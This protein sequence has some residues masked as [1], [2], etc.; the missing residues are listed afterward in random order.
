MA[1]PPEGGL[2]HRRASAARGRL[3]QSFA[4]HMA[5]RPG[6]DRPGDNR[7]RCDGGRTLCGRRHVT[8]LTSRV[9]PRL[10]LHLGAGGS[11]CPRRQRPG[12][13]ADHRRAPQKA[14]GSSADTEGTRSPALPETNV[15][16]MSDGTHRHG[17][18]RL[19]ERV[20]TT[21]S[22]SPRSLP[23]IETDGALILWAG[24]RTAHHLSID[25]RITARCGASDASH[26]VFDGAPFV[27]GEHSWKA[28]QPRLIAR[29]AGPEDGKQLVR[30]GIR[31]HPPAHSFARYSPTRRHGDCT[32]TCE[33]ALLRAAEEDVARLDSPHLQQQPQP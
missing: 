31:R 3:R 6:S 18:S 21:T 23:D 25:F 9:S 28:A 10:H 7:R 29:P 13:Q 1:L 15:G 5:H 24:G 2:L 8:R 26:D 30:A 11:P 22:A 20:L 16:G 33:P 19:M 14:V 4:A 17:P 32:T 12:W 27:R